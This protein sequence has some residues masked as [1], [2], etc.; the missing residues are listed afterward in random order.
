MQYFDHHPDVV[1]QLQEKEKKLMV[2]QIADSDVSVDG[3]TILQQALQ[4]YPQP[5]APAVITKRIIM[6]EMRELAV[7]LTEGHFQDE[8]ITGPAHSHPVRIIKE[9]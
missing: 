8:V 3:V 7:P 6:G 5:I 1:T 4:E 2:V 9:V